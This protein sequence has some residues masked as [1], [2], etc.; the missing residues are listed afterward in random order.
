MRAS[1]WVM[2]STAPVDCGSTP[3]EPVR[4]RSSVWVVLPPAGGA[5]EAAP[6]GGRVRARSG[7]LNRQGPSLGIS[8]ETRRRVPEARIA[9]YLSHSAFGGM[10]ASLESPSA[11]CPD[12]TGMLVLHPDRESIRPELAQSTA[13]TMLPRPQLVELRNASTS[14][15]PPSPRTPLFSRSSPGAEP[16]ASLLTSRPW[17]QSIARAGARRS[18]DR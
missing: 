6:S 5:L 1:P 16:G 7:M 15:P 18:P 10:V 17:V 3:D 11:R 13:A 12:P 8:R 2:P 14:G 9:E 4:C